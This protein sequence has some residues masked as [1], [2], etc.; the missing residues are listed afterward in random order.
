[1]DTQRKFPVY[2]L[3]LASVISRAVFCSFLAVLLFATP[4]VALG[5]A[6]TRGTISGTVVD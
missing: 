1:M 3:A 5:Q 4:R 6:T 2:P